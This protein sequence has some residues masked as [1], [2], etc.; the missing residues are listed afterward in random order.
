MRDHTL[1]LVDRVDQAIAT[2]RW[3]APEEIRAEA[4][5]R[6]RSR[7]AS[8]AAA[9]AVLVGTGAVAVVFGPVRYGERVP[10]AAAQRVEI[11]EQALLQPEDVGP[12]L[13]V[14]D[15]GTSPEQPAFRTPLY[16]DL[17]PTDP[18]AERYRASSLAFRRH[19]IQ[20]VR[21]K[22]SDPYLA[23]VTEAVGRLPAAEAGQVI[24]N[25]LLA[26][27]ACHSFSTPGEVVRDGVV[28]PI[29]QHH[30]W[31]VQA[32][33][34]GGDESVLLRKSSW[35]TRVDTGELL[36]DVAANRVHRIQQVA[37]V[38]VGDLVATVTIEDEDE[39]GIRHLASVAAQRLCRA[40][41]P[42]C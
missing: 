26:M 36:P 10:V 16:L 31:S 22:P 38:R 7:L 29:Q 2:V 20:K 21:T 19:S 32:G 15:V 1:H 35:V 23:V 27:A 17:C 9:L 37:L 14:R 11:P 8:A 34:L 18:A 42:G 41:N 39:D 5:R 4:R 24:N 28:V 12:G 40:A 25:R 13:V 6:T 33:D 3:P 30:G